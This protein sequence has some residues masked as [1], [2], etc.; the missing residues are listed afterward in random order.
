MRSKLEQLRD[1]S[2]VVAEGGD[3]DALRAFQAADCKTNPTLVHSV[4]PAPANDALVEQAIE[5]GRRRTSSL[6][7]D[8]LITTCRPNPAGRW[9]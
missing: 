9:T 2:I 1:V 8:S 6:Y 5:W 4:A 7:Q 3:P